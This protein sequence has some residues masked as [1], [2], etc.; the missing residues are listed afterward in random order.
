M[1]DEEAAA[2]DASMLL[3]M[4]AFRCVQRAIRMLQFPG[5]QADSDV[6]ILMPTI[7]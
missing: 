1:G 4:S 2:S 6:A 3:Q 7:L 5:H